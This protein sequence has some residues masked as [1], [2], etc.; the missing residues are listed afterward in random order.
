[1]SHT[2]PW[3]EEMKKVILETFELDKTSPSYLRNKKL[4]TQPKSVHSNG[5]WQASFRV[6]GKQKFKSCHAIV[7]FLVHGKQPEMVVDHIDGDGFNNTPS[8]LQEISGGQN[9]VKGMDK[10]TSKYKGVSIRHRGYMTRYKGKHVGYYKTEEEAAR[11]YDK[12]V[13]ADVNACRRSKTNK[14]RGL[15]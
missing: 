15:L 9:K 2:K 3:S 14:Q 8:N 5:Y 11:A 6:N 12:A 13:E 1:M 7:Y 10:T 4:G